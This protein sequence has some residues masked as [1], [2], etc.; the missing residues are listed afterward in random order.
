MTKTKINLGSV[1]YQNEYNTCQR[2]AT[3]MSP[4]T[5]T[6]IVQ[7]NDWPKGTPTLF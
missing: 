5:K 3:K 1:V 4:C 2:C 6:G 7:K